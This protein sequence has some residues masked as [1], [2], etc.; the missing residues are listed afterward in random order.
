MVGGE[1]SG[2]EAAASR[3]IQY[4]VAEFPRIT[5]A[6]SSQ[7]NDAS[8]DDLPRGSCPLF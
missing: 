1:E 3:L 6:T 4:S 7:L 8:C 5:L 2:L